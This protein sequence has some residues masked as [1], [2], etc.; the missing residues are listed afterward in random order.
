LTA[1]SF[2]DQ[3]LSTMMITPSDKDYKLTKRI[4]KGEQPMK[5]EFVGL[6]YWI[7]NEYDVKILNI[8]YDFIDNKKKRPRLTIIFEFHKDELR[9]RDIHVGNFHSDKQR[10]IGDKFDEFVNNK[11]TKS[12]ILR[13]LFDN[14]ESKYETN[15]IWVVFTSFEPI[16]KNEANSN[17]SESEVNELI[18]ELDNEHLWEISR[19]FSGTTFFVYTDR[20]VKDYENSEIRKLW[21]QKY[22]DI[23]DKY[24]EFGYFKRDTFSIYLDSKENF[25]TNYQ[26]NWFY[27]YK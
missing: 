27:Y 19:A 20:Q 13:R 6:A 7:E 22:F 3:T 21:T 26:S 4:R 14:K 23:L 15:D 11:T 8:I 12:S 17:V 9:F 5:P 25:D 24:N 18:K 1:T 10:I 2:D 16:A